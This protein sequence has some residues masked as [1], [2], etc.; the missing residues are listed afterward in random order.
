MGPKP[1]LANRRSLGRFTL[2]PGV[3]D[4]DRSTWQRSR[5]GAVFADNRV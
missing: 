2:H 3:G 1:Q 5:I 4:R